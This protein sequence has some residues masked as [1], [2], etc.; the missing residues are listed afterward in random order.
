MGKIYLI[1]KDAWIIVLVLKNEKSIDI[2]IIIGTD[3]IHQSILTIASNKVKI[4]KYQI[5]TKN[6]NNVINSTKLTF[7][8]KINRNSY[9]FQNSNQKV[10]K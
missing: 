8:S 2:D 4:H 9:L 6:S 7:T 5:E 1:V 10:L 3:V